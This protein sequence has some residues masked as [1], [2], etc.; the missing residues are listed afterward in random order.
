MKRK[1]EGYGVIEKNVDYFVEKI[2]S[3]TIIHNFVKDIKDY[4]KKDAKILRKLK[5]KEVI[6]N[7][8]FIWNI[9]LIPKFNFKSS[10]KSKT[11]WFGVESTQ[12]LD[13]LFIINPNYLF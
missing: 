5:N 10:G 9:N 2:D 8:R 3:D 6:S 7:L 12:T 4:S 11:V 13:I 1:N